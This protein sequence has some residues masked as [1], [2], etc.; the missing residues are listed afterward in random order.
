MPEQAMYPH[1]RE[2][3]K[4]ASTWLSF[5]DLNVLIKIV[6]SQIYI[7]KEEKCTVNSPST[8]HWFIIFMGEGKI[9]CIYNSESINKFIVHDK[10]WLI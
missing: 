5:D 1:Q 2:C 10:N 9:V 7:T 4:R 3:V 8:H 6:S